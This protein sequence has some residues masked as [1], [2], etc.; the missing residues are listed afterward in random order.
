[1]NAIHIFNYDK[2]IVT[3]IMIYNAEYNSLSLCNINEKILQNIN[4]IFINV[5]DEISNNYVKNKIGNILKENVMDNIVEYVFDK[6]MIEV[7]LINNSKTNKVTF[8][9]EKNLFREVAYF[10]C[11]QSFTK[12]DNYEFIIPDCKYLSCLEKLTNYLNYPEDNYLLIP[13]Y[14]LLEKFYMSLDKPKEFFDEIFKNNYDDIFGIKDLMFIRYLYMYLLDTKFIHSVNYFTVVHCS[15]EERKNT[16]DNNLNYK[17][18][19]VHLENKQSEISIIVTGNIIK[20]F[21]CSMIYISKNTI[22]YK[23]ENKSFLFKINN[24]GEI[25]NIKLH[26]DLKPVRIVCDM[27]VYQDKNNYICTYNH[28][29]TSYKS[30]NFPITFMTSSKDYNIKNIKYMNDYLK[31]TE[32]Y[33]FG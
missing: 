15:F 31:C 6:E 19:L 28:T 33:L 5:D 8:V 4:K 20:R 17:L 16:L 14:K 12:K 30:F 26:L 24:K 3:T 11:A 22:Y 29:E 13:Q 18:N 25:K 9:I 2:P 1:M 27:I 21:I 7:N 23:Y 32:K 10:L